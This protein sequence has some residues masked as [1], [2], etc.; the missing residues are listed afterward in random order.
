MTTIEALKQTIQNDNNDWFLDFLDLFDTSNKAMLEIIQQAMELY[1]Q[2]CTIM[3]NTIIGIQL[4]S[5]GGEL[6]V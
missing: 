4:E 6:N 3:D 2:N 5:S 1:A